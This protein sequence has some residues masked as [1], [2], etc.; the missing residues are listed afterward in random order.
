MV[1]NENIKPQNDMNKEAVF[2]CYE[3]ILDTC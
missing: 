2:I 3:R 1:F